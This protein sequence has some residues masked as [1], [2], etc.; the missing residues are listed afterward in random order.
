MG[1]VIM[2][3][4]GARSGKSR[5]A[6]EL[7]RSR[8][9]KAFI[10]TATACDGEMAERIARHREERSGDFVTIEEPMDL[11]GAVRSLP[12]GTDVAI[13]DCLT[14][15]LGN[16]MHHSG[17]IAGQPPEVDAFLETLRNPPCDLVIVTNEVGMGIVPDNE[18]GRK[19]RDLAGILNA[20]VAGIAANVVLLVSGIPIH[21]KGGG[22]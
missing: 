16:L 17:G 18:L 13:V 20:R 15:W 1:K 2:L 22:L 5:Y 14:V 12:A 3:T 6:L 8:G 9:R 10:A 4:G 11:A 19:F 21:I 7:V